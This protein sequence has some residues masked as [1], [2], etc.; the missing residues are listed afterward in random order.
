GL[1]DNFFDLGGDSLTAIHLLS[2]LGQAL[3]TTLPS[4]SLLQTPTIAELAA[5]VAPL[6]QPTNN[7]AHSEPSPQPHIIVELQAGEKHRQPL[8]LVHPI[9]GGVYGYRD[10]V[11]AL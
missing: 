6:V 3:N 9:G 2:K 5:A 10:L 7:E 4:H 11:Q 8:F 1:H